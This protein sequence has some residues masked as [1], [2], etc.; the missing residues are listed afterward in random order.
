MINENLKNKISHFVNSLK[1]Y[2]SY[3]EYEKWLAANSDDDELNKMRA[4]FG[5]LRK[6]FIENQNNG[7]VTQEEI[8][9]LREL[10]SEL[11]SHPIVKNL[12]NSQNDLIPILQLCN[13]RISAEIGLDF[14]QNAAPSSCCG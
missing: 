14:A 5:K 12:I 4:E 3:T 10:Q 7:N 2:D 11:N 8:N 6:H 13:Q 1:N 9:R